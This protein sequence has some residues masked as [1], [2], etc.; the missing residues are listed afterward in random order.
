MNSPPPTAEARP[1]EGRARPVAA[2]LSLF[3]P[4]V[5]VVVLL[6]LIGGG[7]GGAVAWLA[8]TEDGSRWLLARLPN[9]QVDGLRG[10]LFDD[11]VAAERVRVTWSG[12]QASV[13]ITGFEGRGLRWR[14]HPAPGRWVGIDAAALAAREVIVDTGPP[15]G[16][17][18]QRPTS[19]GI[20]L[21][22][23]SPDVRVGLL[24]INAIG[25]WRDVSGHARVGPG[26]RYEL[27]D[28][29][30]AW[31]R[32]VIAGR[33]SLGMSPPFALAGAVQV[34]PSAPGALAASG[35]AAD[36]TAQLTAGGTLERIELA[37]A[38]TGRPTAGRSAPRADA[39]MT[40]LP[41][42]PW[43]LGALSARTEAL[44]L[45]ALASGLPETRLAGRVELTTRG[46]DAPAGAEVRLTNGLPGRWNEGR[47]PLAELSLDAQTDLQR[48]ERIEIQAFD[49]RLAGTRG[50]AAGRVSGR[51]SWNGDTLALETTLAELRPQHLDGR[52]AA[53]QLAGPL[54]LRVTGLPSPAAGGAPGTGTGPGTST[55]P[56]SAPAAAPGPLA[57]AVKATLDGRLDAAPQPVQLVL[58]AEADARRIDVRELRARSGAALAQFN[59]SAQRGAPGGA[60]RIASAGTLTDFDPLPWWPGDATQTAWRRGPHRLS[61]GW[62]LDLRLPP[63]AERLATPVLL[64]RL[65][66]NGE[67]RVHDSVLAGVPLAMELKLAQAPVASS[68]PGSPGARGPAAP[69]SL[70]GSATIGPNRLT[71]DAR[72]DP[73]GEGPNAG[74]GD[75]L[76]LELDAPS[77]ATLAPLARLV[78]AA[79]G[80]APRAGSAKAGARVQGRWPLLR[81][82][83]QLQIS[84]VDSA[85]GAIAQ[86]RADWQLQLDADGRKP[87]VVKAEL[88]GLR[89]GR[90]RLQSLRAEL[91]GTPREHRLTVSA[92]LPLVPPPVL[93]Q[94]FGVRA[95]SGSRAQLQGDGAWTPAAGGGGSWRGR[96]ARLAVGAWDGAALDGDTRPSWVDAR[97]LSAELRFDAQGE[98]VSLQAAP[99]RVRLAEA[100]ALRWDAIAVT[101]NGERTDIDLRADLDAFRVAPLL[102][103]AQPG[104]AW[105]GDLTLAGRIEL[106]A[107]ER[108]QAEMVFER[109]GGDLQVVDEAGSQALGLTDLR[110]ALSARDGQWTFTQ[111]FA[112]R[113]IGEMAGLLQ[114]KTAAE[115]RWP[116]ADAPLDGVLQARVA[117]LAVWA[118]WVPAG[119]RLG[120]ELATQATIAGRWGAPEYTGEIRGNGLSVRNLLQ[121]VN[122][123][124]GELK[125][126]LQ[127]ETAQIERFVLRGG[128]GSLTVSGGAD[129]GSAP[130]ARLRVAAERFRVLGR[131]DR[132]LSLSGAAEAQLAAERIAVD[133]RF[134]VDEGLFDISRADAPALDDDV[135]VRRA[136]DPP[137]ASA[138]GDAAPRP[139]RDLAV[140]LAVD[141]GENL[142][143][144]G[145]GI[146]TAL[147]GRLRLT[148]PNGRLAVAGTVRTEGGTYQA[149]GQKLDIARGIVAFSG[150][151]DNPRLDVLAL[152]PNL[153]VQVGVAITGNLLTPR[154]R[155][156][157]EPEMSDSDRLSWLVLGR[158]SEGL[159]RND[160]ALLQRAAF[161]LL[162]GEGDTPTDALIRNLGLDELT[163]GQRESGDV[164]ET[165]V[166]LGKQLSRRW[167]VG[168]ERGVNA[169]TGTWQ[170]IYRIAQRFTLRAQSGLEN[171]ID[172]IWTWKFDET[173][174]LPLRGPRNPSA[175][176]RGA[177][178]PKSAASAPP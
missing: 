123:T 97:D 99:G 112:G 52:A 135:T 25:P 61:A 2:A 174:L 153:D 111:A 129:F 79:A 73:L 134:V 118:P 75:R 166:S 92:A 104:L 8:R 103:R 66:G 95:L 94:L 50:V 46:R 71:I 115:R 126:A 91:S 69:S 11:A 76:V 121:G 1:L 101:R 10:A 45:A 7:I 41:Y 33:A 110:L 137:P 83:G 122:L 53:M 116:G 93:E 60:W 70:L 88:G 51:G 146:D 36:F 162:A 4:L 140:T 19:I 119:W 107:A 39:A 163:V 124:Q 86:G 154:V 168:Y 87:L 127:G 37:A 68:A 160:T 32:L 147:A 24:K 47:L 139:R 173:P 108:F 44:D 98:L 3:W 138:S 40:V 172:I 136:G 152:R 165:V 89:W 65:A 72:G 132:R 17:P 12:G 14:W 15:S 145:R 170:L 27:L 20:P 105:Q 85:E 144:R 62:Q 84:G 28:T 159:G 158:A 55:A 96:I 142:R 35:P 102:A 34:T 58:D 130:N 113:A 18:S 13:T 176:G 114:V 49:A 149:Y 59:A 56:G 43:W 80:W 21:E 54:A 151:L 81:T 29:R 128:E 117:N 82:E 67:L 5:W 30:F 175:Q 78:P 77:L 106:K 90:Q 38:L 167:Y 177:P 143:L 23:V 164:R 63:G 64:Q 157:S 100:L 22:I 57:L 156:Y 42:A 178:V 48:H 74:A 16:A 141:L 148:T 133:G 31:D 120:G 171:S 26:D 109:T 169:A 131:V 125:I 155:L 161:A 9:V 150:P 6:A